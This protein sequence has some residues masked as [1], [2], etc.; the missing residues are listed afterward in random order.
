MTDEQAAPTADQEDPDKADELGGWSVRR[1]WEKYED[2][3]MHFNDLLIR[4]RMQALGVVA[5]LSTLIGIFTKTDVAI[6]WEI[7]AGVFGG[8]FLFWIAI[9]ILDF[10]YYNRLLIG[11]VAAL[12]GIEQKSSTQTRIRHIE[13]STLIGNAVNGKLDRQLQKS[14][15]PTT[16]MWL[17]YIIVSLALAGGFSFSLYRHLYPEVVIAQPH[18]E[19]EIAR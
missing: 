16:G 3:A 11:A 19:A 9:W 10:G 6:T 8:L 4:L 15:G 13:I 12:V 5:A 14:L 2:I 18:N 1:L 7:A 17:F